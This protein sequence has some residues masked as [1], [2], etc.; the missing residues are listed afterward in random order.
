M[1]FFFR[2]QINES[3]LHQRVKAA[4]RFI[5]DENIRVMHKGGHDSQFL[6]HPFAHLF[7]PAF[8]VQ[9][10]TFQQFVPAVQAADPA[11]FRD[12]FQEF[13]AGH[14]FKEADL[15]GNVAQ[16]CLHL[17]PFVPAI[18]TVDGTA[19]RLRLQKSH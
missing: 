15:T 17:L 5:E 10:K 12:K 9:G 11:V 8:G 14:I 7:D 3:A 16:S 6:F 1:L 19:S 2:D 13:R 4:G 18:Q